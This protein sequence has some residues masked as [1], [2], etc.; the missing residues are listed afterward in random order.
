MFR[1]CRGGEWASQRS[2]ELHKVMN[3]RSRR[4]ALASVRIDVAGRERG[5]G[6]RQ[7]MRGSK[8]GAGPTPLSGMLD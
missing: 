1:I 2:Q 3:G 6:Q 8:R 7:K 4:L 5:E